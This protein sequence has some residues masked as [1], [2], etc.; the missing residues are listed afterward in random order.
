MISWKRGCEAEHEESA[1]P[2]ARSATSLGAVCLQ[3]VT[4]SLRSTSF[5]QSA[6]SFICAA[7]CGNDVEPRLKRCCV[8]HANDVVPAAQMKKSKS[9]DLDFLGCV[10]ELD[11][12]PCVADLDARFFYRGYTNPLAMMGAKSFRVLPDF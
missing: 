3:T 7:C 6:T 8:C 12:K 4:T 11:A 5:A 2:F 9:F 1:C 10:S